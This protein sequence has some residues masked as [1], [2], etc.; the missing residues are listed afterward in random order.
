MFKLR[1]SK[2]GKVKLKIILLFSLCKASLLS[3]FGSY[4]AESDE[5]RS[6]ALSIITSTGLGAQN[7][8]FELSLICF[9]V[10]FGLL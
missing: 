7:H 6:H 3:G 10:G 2:H 4:E 5:V 8:Y 9:T 1:Y